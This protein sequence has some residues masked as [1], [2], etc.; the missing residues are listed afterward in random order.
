[1]KKY[2]K[3][4]GHRCHCL[5]K[6]YC[7]TDVSC[8]SCSCNECQCELKPL[9]LGRENIKRSKKFEYYTI[10]ILLILI[11]IVTLSG[12]VKEEQYPNK[13]GTIA[14]KLSELKL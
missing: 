9:V 8:E 10:L 12:C 6:G 5:G 13:M 4:C 3:T 11:F 7:V 1:M 14:K 2:C